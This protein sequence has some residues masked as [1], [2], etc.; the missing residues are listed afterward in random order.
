M[1]SGYSRNDL[2]S[3]YNSNFTESTKSS[4]INMTYRFPRSKWSLS[5]NLNIAQRTQDST[6]TVSFPNVTLT[7]SQTYPFK[8]KKAVGDE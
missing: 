5:T 1:T 2:N 3:Y 8:R 4:T 7:M 6:L